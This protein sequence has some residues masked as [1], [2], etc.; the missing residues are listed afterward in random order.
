MKK[1]K[2]NHH[3]KWYLLYSL[4]AIFIIL[5]VFSIMN[6]YMQDIQNQLEHNKQ[7]SEITIKTV[8]EVFDPSFEFPVLQKTEKNFVLP[9]IL[10]IFGIAGFL[11]TKY[12]YQK[13]LRGAK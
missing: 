7:L 4:F 1:T 11:F 5:G 12:L 3:P 13:Q 8:N 9:T 6:M 10:I 2:H